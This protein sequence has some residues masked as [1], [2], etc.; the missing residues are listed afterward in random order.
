MFPPA[1]PL[2]C[3]TT[4]FPVSSLPFSLLLFS[5]PPRAAHG[6]DCLPLMV[7]AADEEREAG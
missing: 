1:F 2:I 5:R 6:V 3:I 7:Q 4:S